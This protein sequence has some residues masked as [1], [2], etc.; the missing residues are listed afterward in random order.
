MA[1]AIISSNLPVLRPLFV[2]NSTIAKSHQ[3]GCESGSNNSHKRDPVGDWSK[4][5]STWSIVTGKTLEAD[6]RPFAKMPEPNA[7]STSEGTG[8]VDIHVETK[9][10]QH[11][12]PVE[13]R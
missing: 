7:I 11:Y 1:V 4:P 9:L 2:R 13:G 12:H 8:L 6:E 10:Q 3:S 5:R